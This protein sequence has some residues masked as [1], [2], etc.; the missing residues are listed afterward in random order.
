[1]TANLEPGTRFPA[2]G[3]GQ[4][5]DLGYQPYRGV[6]QGRPRA[7]W[8]LYSTS[9]RA[10]FGIGRGGKAKIVPFLLLGLALIPA[11]IALGIAALLGENFSPIRYSNYLNN[12]ALLL[13]LFC[14][15]VAPEL[16][17]PDQRNRVLSL[18]FAHAITRLDY[19]LMK[20]LALLTALLVIALLPQALLFTGNALAAVDGGAYVRD[21][22]GVI[23][24]IL[25]AGLLV[26]VFL[27]GLSLAAASLTSRRIFAA[28]GFIALLTISTATAN[29]LWETFQ[30]E[31]ARAVML[32]SLGDLSYAAT[33]WVFA[34]PYESGSLAYRTDLPGA[35]LF[36]A[37][38]TYAAIGLLI[39]VWRYL[40]WE[41]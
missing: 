34:A 11:A 20:G 40:R 5:F 17:C 37:V 35:L 24:R 28:G 6:R 27:A 8:A 14:A 41:P 3:T 31:A 39:V 9:L 23:P 15:T 2:P 30:T 38:L 21:N 36:L 32:A 25:A 18:Y 26:S 29:V 33:F 1:M 19:V 12:T 10:A 7:C 4:I 13:G 16:L 22:L